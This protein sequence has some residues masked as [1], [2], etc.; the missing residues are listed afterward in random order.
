MDAR[1]PASLVGKDIVITGIVRS[2]PEKRGRGLRFEMEVLEWDQPSPAPKR[3]RLS[4]YGKLD[5]LTAGDRWRLKVRL[6]PPHGFLN[7][8]GFDYEKWLF[9]NAITAVGYVKKDSG[10]VRLD[11]IPVS[12]N[13]WRQGK[14]VQLERALGDLPTAGTVVALTLGLRDGVTQEQWDL[15]RTTGT[16]HLMAISG[17]HIGLVAGLTFWLM[18]LFWRRCAKCCEWLASPRAA[19]WAAITS[20]LLYAAMAG[21]SVPTQRAFIMLSVVMVAIIVGRTVRPWYS[22]GLAL[23][24]V[25]ILDTKAVL[26]PGFWLSFYAVAV[27]L[28]SYSWLQKSR[29]WMRVIG[30][31]LALS[32]SFIPLTLWFFGEASLV[33]PLANL[34]AV[35]TV[36]LL[37]VPLALLGSIMLSVH[38]E[39]GTWLLG[40]AAWSLEVLEGILRFLAS[41]PYASVSFPSPSFVSVIAAT[42]GVL[43][44]FTTLKRGWKVLSPVLLLPIFLSPRDAPAY[45]EALVTFLDVGQGLSTVIQTSEHTLVFDLGAKFSPRFDAVS[46]VILPYLGRQGIDR[47]DTLVISHD[48]LDH[49]GATDTFLQKVAVSRLLTSAKGNRFSPFDEACVA[50]QQ[51]SWDGVSFKVLHPTPQWEGEDND[52][53]C[54]IKVET[55]HGSA[56]LTGD[57]GRR[58]ESHLVKNHSTMLSAEILQV[59]HHGSATSSSSEFI[60]AVS[61]D[62]AVF[63]TGYANRYGF[64][65]PSVEQRYLDRGIR[66]AQTDKT[67]AIT[68]LLG[69]GLEKEQLKNGRPITFWRIQARRF[70]HE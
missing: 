54:V 15:L 69:K 8:G 33:A 42:V 55:K 47:I 21:F 28:L 60:D 64:P 65:R 51:W 3:I 25:L 41:A 5:A 14:E 6:K 40:L 7:P 11:P 46:A 58:S 30:I 16:S 4:S 45:G 37:T 2:V 38:A 22:L 59:P 9:Q 53:S 10:N 66:V 12:L 18:N 26:S 48:D 13:R 67:G 68:I 17:L 57:I 34:V 20:G 23:V 44:W 29:P 62:F 61:P 27:I 39:F 1:L 24:L 50:G 63:N 32:A 56:L 43:V 31:Q 49:Y 19:A 70:W 35:P 52:M 36:S